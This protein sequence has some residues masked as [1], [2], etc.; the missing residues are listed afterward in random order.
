M[1]DFKDSMA[2][3]TSQAFRNVAGS[4]PAWCAYIALG[5]WAFAA[6]LHGL[7][8]AINYDEFSDSTISA[9]L[10]NRTH[11]QDD[12][13]MWNSN[14]YY[15]DSNFQ[16]NLYWD[17]L[18]EDD[19]VHGFKATIPF[20]ER[21]E[22]TSHPIGVLPYIGL[23]GD[24][25]TLETSNQKKLTPEE[26]RALYEKSMGALIKSEPFLKLLKDRPAG[27]GILRKVKTFAIQPG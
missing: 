4:G 26:A 21:A 1:A 14:C 8:T 19:F 5:V 13:N 11:V 7:G 9:H 15:K 16:D 22:P 18:K 12:D 2:G 27:E 25:T 10:K 17:S 20:I 6:T 3:K 23:S 24:C